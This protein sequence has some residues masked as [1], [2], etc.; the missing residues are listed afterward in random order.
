V[1]SRGDT[2]D[3]PA[4][5]LHPRRERLESARSA[6]ADAATGKDAWARLVEA[7]IVPPALATGDRRFAVVET[8]W[9]ASPTNAEGVT[10]A[11]VP[12][13]VNSAIT[14]GSDAAGILA[15]EELARTLRARLEP[16]GALP[17]SET[18]WIILTH[19]VRFN[20]E[21]GPVFNAVLYSV[22]YA[23]E[24]IGVALKE[25]RP[26]QPWLPPFV[27]DVL[28]ARDGWA[29]AAAEGLD[30]PGAYDV[31]RALV[32]TPFE[33]LESPFD[34]ALEIW[35]NGYVIDHACF[36]NA[37]PIRLFTMVIDAPQNLRR[38]LLDR[39][40]AKNS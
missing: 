5:L 4:R 2:G 16:W 21:Q 32:G 14:I 19:Q 40:R 20:F 13:T 26:D 15:T 24:E 31:P 33:A 39:A 27:N 29:R 30:V 35:A 8:G 6:A 22:E 17:P 37:A 25:L 34:A 36:D 18:R 9:T 38:T 1:T 10:L 7:G 28:R 3:L 12:A 23:L 11:P